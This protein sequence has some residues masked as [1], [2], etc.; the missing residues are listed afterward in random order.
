MESRADPI[1]PAFF[2]DPLAVILS[3]NS[4]AD[5]RTVT[6]GLGVAEGSRWATLRPRAR[7]SNMPEGERSRLREG[8]VYCLK[9]F[10]ATRVGLLILG[11]I[12]VGLFLSPPFPPYLVPDWPVRPIPD[13]GWHAI[14][15]A[16]ERFDA[17]WY[18]RIATYGYQPGNGTAYFFPLYPLVTRAVSWGIGWHPLAAGFI[19]SNLSF[20]GGI[21]VLYFL[22]ASELSSSVARRTILYLS[23]FPTA[24]WFFAPYTESLLLL[25]TVT[26]FWAARRN[27]WWLAGIAGALAALTHFPGLLVAP[28]LGVEAFSQWRE[29]RRLLPRFFWSGFVAIGTAMY[30]GFWWRLTGEP[31]GLFHEDTKG[32]Y[33]TT[34][35][36]TLIAGTSK[37]FGSAGQYP[38]GHFFIDLIFVA[39][40]LAAAILAVRWLRPCYAVFAWASLLL[41]LSTIVYERPLVGMPRYMLPIFPLFWVLALAVERGR[42]PHEVVVAVEAAGFGLLTVLFVNWGIS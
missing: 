38:D 26:A 35:W 3:C 29:G 7:S 31:L 19:V 23:V 34:P 9:V 41:P 28:A 17:L 12:G 22:T 20:L 40:A 16:W 24:F 5:P 21:C 36:R 42:I 11:F 8:V 33:V 4:D 14:F 2:V 10:V 6:W 30:V 15:T 27:R 13:P 1:C 37:A 39:L 18:L 25:L 32:R